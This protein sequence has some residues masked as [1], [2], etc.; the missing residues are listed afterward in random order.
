MAFIEISGLKKSFGNQVVLKNISFSV[1]KNEVVAI[2]GPSGSGKSTLL[3]SMVQLET[4]DAGSVAIDGEYFIKDGRYADSKTV[5]SLMTK[6]GMVFQQ[7]HLFPH[8]TVRENLEIAPRIVKKE[9][10]SIVARKSE[11]LLKKVGLL[12]K[13]DAYPGKLSGGQKQRVA[14]ARALMMEPEIMLFD[15]PT[16]AL[17]PEL[18]GEVL[19]VMRALVKEQMTMLVVTHEMEFAREVADRVIFMDGG[20]IVEMGSPLT[21]F[22][23]PRHERTKLFLKRVV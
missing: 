23:N 22:T 7:F 4:V 1:E 5:K 3:R 15:E 14:I 17:D 2:I 18:T 10:A 20:E 8:L 19:Q 11:E 9:D 12:D 16:S 13:S 6:I 21:I